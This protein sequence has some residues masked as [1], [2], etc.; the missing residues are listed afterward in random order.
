MREQELSG[1]LTAPLGAPTLDAAAP[2][3]SGSHPSLV[4][5]VQFANQASLGTTPADWHNRFFGS[6]DSLADYYDEVSFGNVEFVPANE[7]HG[8]A[9]DGVVGWLTLPTNHPNTQGSTGTANQQ[10]TAD[11]INAANPYVNFASYDTNHNGLI[12]NDELHI[13][14]IPAGWEASAGCGTPAVWGH[15]WGT[16]ALTP[17]VDGVFAGVT[18]T[19][20]GEKHCDP[21]GTFGARPP[22]MATLGI[23]AHEMGHDLDLPDLYDTDN[24][25]YG[26]VGYWSVMAYG[27]WLNLPNTDPGTSPPHLDAF[28]KAYEGWI[29]PT[30]AGDGTYGLLDAAAN[31]AALQVRDNPSGVDWLFGSH[32]GS[33][34]YFLIENRQRT[35][36]DGALPSCGVLIWHIDETRSFISPNAAEPDRL[37]ALEE[38]DNDNY[39]FEAAD[40]FVGART[41][42][43]TSTPNSN[44]YDGTPSGVSVSNFS[45]ACGSSMSVAVDAPGTTAHPP[46][47]SDGSVTTSED[48]QYSFTAGSF[49][50]SDA[51]AG[52][53]FDSVRI[54]SLP[55]VGSLKAGGVAATAGSS[56]APGSLTYTP[57]ANACGPSY[58]SFTFSVRDSSGAYDTSPNTIT[59]HV[60]CVDDA[61]TAV[62]DS[63]TVT[64][65]ASATTIDVRANDTD[66][67]AGTKTVQGVSLAAH[68]TV[69]VTN[70]GA[71]V[72]YT[73]AS[74][75]CGADSFNYT[76]NGGSSAT[77]NISVT[78][79]DD[80]PVASNDSRTVTE[81]S[82]A[83]GMGVLANDFDVDSGPRTIGSKTNGAHGQ[84]AI[85]STGADVT[86]APDANYCGPDSFTYTLNGGSTATVNVTVACVD[87][88]PVALSDDKSVAEDSG[89]NTLDVRSN[90]TDVDAGPMT[91]A[92]N[93]SASHGVVAI[94]NSNTELRYTPALNYCGAD[95]FTYTLNG[96]STATVNVTVTCVDDAPVAVNDSKTANE[97]A[98]AVTVDVRAN[99]TDIDAGTKSIASKT[100]GAHGGVAITNSGADLTYT[101]DADYCGGDSFTYTLN[102]GSTATVTI[103][104]TCIDDAPVAVNDTRSLPE[105]A[106]ASPLDVRNNDTDVDGGLKA[107]VATTGPAHGSLGILAGDVTYAPASNYCGDDSFTYTLNGGSTATVNVTVTCVDDAPSAVDDSKTLDEDASA[108]TI[109]VLAN[110]TDIDGGAKS[111]ASKTNGTHGTVAIT[112]SGADLTY[113]PDANYCGTDNFTYTLNGGSSATANVTVTCTD[114]APSAVNDAKT[115]DEDASATTIDVLANDTDIDGG[116]KTITAKTNGAHGTV[117]ITNSGADLTYRPDANYCGA[118]NFTYTLN[119][120]STATVNVTV[121]CADDAPTAVD[122][123]QTVS[124]NAATSST[125]DALTNDT[126]IDGGTMTIVSKTDGAHGTVEITNAG[127]SL[128][129]TPDANYCGPDSFTYTL[130]GGSTA[131]VEITVSCPDTP[132]TAVNDTKTVR[133]D[134]AAVTID[135]RA[136]DTDADGGSKTV[137][138]RTNGGHGAVTITHSG[139]DL[140]YKP[141]A[142]YCGTDGFRYTLNGGSTATVNVTVTCVDDAPVALDDA[143]AVAEDAWA[144][145]DVRGNDTDIDGGLKAI[146]SKTNAAHGASAITTAGGIAYRPAPNYCGADTLTYTLN[147]GS[148][149]TVAIAVACAPEDAPAGDQDP[150][151]TTIADGP[152][153]KVKTKRRRARVSF[154][155]ESSEDGST[156]VCKL[157]DGNFKACRSSKTYRLKPGRHVL[158]VAAVD[159]A[160]NPDATPV[161]KRIK[162]V[163]IPRG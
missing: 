23:M 157:D 38:G 108:T 110:D 12:S 43:A 65:D 17:V 34:E 155:F 26:G 32:V 68:G 137:M 13:T 162:V 92:T 48:T 128:G 53:T 46:T 106:G 153:R 72:A 90:D 141:A 146:V 122:D 158:W 36:Y 98:S 31:P 124:R 116:T 154:E 35:G 149:A 151:E 25:S 37:V 45:S 104:I 142:N 60:T 83:S 78:C 163:R 102:G 112:N 103:T 156:F 66:I 70:A 1:P 117:A 111:I 131:T 97:D 21:T 27:S 52:D 4:L 15:K 105:D 125:I 143:G 39:P 2:L 24:S 80:A 101:P 74:N 75:Y 54:D 55:A 64:E 29:T 19:Q 127:D 159:A 139:A 42:N 61:P 20:F 107:I 3:N 5:L 115:L 138:A 16:G 33:G 134:A 28:S 133:E 130:N 50:F 113:T 89:A 132:P 87:D 144:I 7:T 30:A 100:N 109:D 82:A 118:D 147:G 49:G 123:S 161:K 14:V 79:V 67:D 18:Y 114:D 121:T 145:F 11:A 88:P 140:T 86:Y 81:D 51:D 119:G 44:L 47:G 76:L 94:I 93:T 69:A 160:G 63:K 40:S 58:A 135:V 126:D 152:G 71:D 22:R 91:I 99:D 73:P 136:N 62:N 85:V 120:G 129:Y 8:T 6:S 57:P 95:S 56:Y 41:F 10:L 96:G 77:V 150:P 9:N 59:V 148:T 84:V